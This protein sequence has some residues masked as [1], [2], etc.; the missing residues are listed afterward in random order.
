MQT[1]AIGIRAHSGWAAIVTIA[2][3]PPDIE[4]L[5]RRRAEICDP[6]MAGAKQP[7][8]FVEEMNL[9]KAEKHL[10]KC[11]EVSERL[12]KSALRDLM[13]RYRIVG[14]SILLASGRAL[15]PLP[16]I[17]ASHAMIHTAEGEF[18]RRSFQS[19]CASLNLAIKGV[20]ERELGELTPPVWQQRVSEM[21]RRIGPPWTQDQKIAALAAC[22]LLGDGVKKDTT[23]VSRLR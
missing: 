10:A 11:A 18:F 5:D 1:A 12:A 15:P 2:G 6:K 7:Y 13:E 16:A 9:S 19:A 20:R 21:G 14:A 3:S 4:I 17:L 22:L 8:H 23:G